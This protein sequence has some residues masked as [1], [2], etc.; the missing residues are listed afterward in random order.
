MGRTTGN[1]LFKTAISAACCLMILGSVQSMD[2]MDMDSVYMSEVKTVQ[3]NNAASPNFTMSYYTKNNYNTLQF[4]AAMMLNSYVV[5]GWTADRG[6]WTILGIETDSGSPYHD[7][8]HCRLPTVS[9]NS[10]KDL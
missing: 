2:G 8:V 6:L 4:H 1:K 9:F 7:G 5:T 10:T 3:L